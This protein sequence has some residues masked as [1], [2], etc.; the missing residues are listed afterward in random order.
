MMMTITMMIMIV[1]ATLTMIIFHFC[2]EEVDIVN[3]DPTAGGCDDCCGCGCDGYYDFIDDEYEHVYD[4][5][6]DHDKI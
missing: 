3:F 2:S 1:I 4:C 6:Y 5:N